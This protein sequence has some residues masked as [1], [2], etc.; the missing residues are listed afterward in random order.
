MVYTCVH[1][2][3]LNLKEIKQ[4]MARQ[5]FVLVVCPTELNG[6]WF[7]ILFSVIFW[8]IES[9]DGSNSFSLIFLPKQEI[10]LFGSQPGPLQ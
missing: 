1:K 5:H 4:N 9:H 3:A 6:N 7:L 2:V 10:T 8:Y